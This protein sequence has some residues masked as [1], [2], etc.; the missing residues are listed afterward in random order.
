MKRIILSVLLAGTSALVGCSGNS[1]TSDPQ[2][3]PNIAGQWEMIASPNSAN[4][5]STGVELSLKEGQMLI[6]SGSGSYEPNGQVSAS[7]TQIAFVGINATGPTTDNFVFG[8]NCPVAGPDTGG[9]RLVGSVS[10]VG[11]SFNFTYTENGNDFTVTG[12]IA[13]DGKSMTGTYTSQAGSNCSDGDSGVIIGLVVPKLAGTYL[14]QLCQPAD[15]SCSAAKDN[16][17]AT[18][19][20]KGNTLTVN[21]VLSGVDNA[22]LSLTGPVSGNF[23]SVQGTF[24]GQPIAYYGYYQALLDSADGLYDIQNIYLANSASPTQLSGTLTVPILP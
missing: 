19:K 2:P 13:A 3:L 16:A 6:T 12:N 15:P 1:S 20:Q 17:T 14:G 7:G 24:Q 11:G 5:T 4:G 21:L 10:G 8:G 23:F 9:N 22:T 18:L